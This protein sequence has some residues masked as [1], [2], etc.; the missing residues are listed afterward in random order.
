M[1]FAIGILT[2]NQFS[3]ERHELFLRTVKSLTGQM[4]AD[5]SLYIVDN[6]SGDET[7]AYVASLGGTCLT[8]PLNSCG[9]GMNATISICAAAEPDIVLFSNDDI[10]WAP[11]AL[12]RLAAFW[13]EAPADLIIASGLM[14]ESFPWNVARERIE[15]GGIEGLVRDSAPGGA[16]TMRASNWGLVRPVPEAPGWDDVPTCT[17]LRNKGYRVAQLDLADHLGEDL[18]TWANDS[19]RWERPLDRAAWG[20][21]LPRT[22]I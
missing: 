8:G 6:N 4:T 18:S 22:G 7:A 3:H 20:L 13:A 15:F 2:F 12:T 1:R 21:S 19:K 9:R 10:L 17:R 16:W 5:D 11:D 14:E